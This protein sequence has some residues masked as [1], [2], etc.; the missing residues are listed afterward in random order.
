MNGDSAVHVQLDALLVRGSYHDGFETSFLA[1]VNQ[2]IDR[3]NASSSSSS[4]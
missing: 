4:N 2:P 3:H 1:T